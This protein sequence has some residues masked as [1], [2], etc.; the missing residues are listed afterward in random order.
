MHRSQQVENRYSWTLAKRV[1]AEL[2]LLQQQKRLW[3]K[4][5]VWA[6]LPAILIGT[7]FFWGLQISLL[8]TWV[9]SVYL[10]GYFVFTALSTW[11]GMWLKRHMLQKEVA[12]LLDE[13]SEIK[14]ELEA[15]K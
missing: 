2:R 4:A 5:E 15:L 12:P 10:I 11:G 1:D 13:L 3:G 14:S 7:S 6:F 9:P 8:G